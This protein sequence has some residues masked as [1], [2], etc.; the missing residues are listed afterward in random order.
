MVR[1]PGLLST[2]LISF[3][4]G[5]TLWA[6][7][8]VHEQQ[9]NSVDLGARQAAE[10]TTSNASALPGL[11]N[12]GVANPPD[13]PA[14][15]ISRHPKAIVTPIIPTEVAVAPPPVPQ[16]PLTK[17]NIPSIDDV[18]KIGDRNVGK[19]LDFY[20]LDKEI[21]LGREMAHEV[22]AESRVLKDPVIEEY[23]NRV[24]Q[25]LVRNSDAKV[26]FTIKVLDNDEVN[27]FALPGGFFYVNTGLI[28]AADNE[29]EL[30]GVM[31]HEIAHV[32]ARHATK[33]QTR[34]EIFNLA[35]IPLVFVGGPAGYA[36]RQVLGLA[37]PLSM[38]KF[39]RNAEREADMLGLEYQYAAGYDP[40]EFVKFF[41]KLE[42]GE[43]QHKNFL[44]K[45]FATHPM[46]KDRIK[47]A[48]QEI[49][50]YLPAREDYIV[51]T[52]QFQDVKRRLENIEGEHRIDGGKVGMPTLRKRTENDR[53][54][55]L[56]RK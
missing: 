15:D 26:P 31:A 41:E 9:A 45:A 30:A 50:K 25:N 39:S 19:G 55:K 43:K 10:R 12:S 8:P 18:N 53:P 28:L 4:L 20:S 5:T 56:E 37:M 16:I 23:I 33:N 3:L 36:V 47:R 6:Q 22:E 38:L 2:V 48:Q 51:D 27:A 21:A 52:S 7:E 46:T 13:L 40:E 32:A 44:A 34:S 24:G 54:P 35:S 17:K 14:V 49:T 1:V 29:A 11:S 42:L